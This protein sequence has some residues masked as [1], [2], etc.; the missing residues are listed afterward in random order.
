M[1]KENPQHPGVLLKKQ[2]QSANIKAKFV[3]EKIHVSNS[4]FGDILNGKRRITP[5]IAL[6]LEKEFGYR[7][8][9]WVRLQADYELEV[10]RIEML[11]DTA[12]RKLS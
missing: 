9:D 1:E 2:L 4:Q 11:Q 6:L 10:E 8:K 5:K 12:E 7:A 3:A